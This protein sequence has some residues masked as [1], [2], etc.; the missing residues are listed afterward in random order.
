MSCKTGCFLPWHTIGT[1][2]K[3]NELMQPLESVAVAVPWSAS[4]GILQHPENGQ[5]IA[6]LCEG[7]RDFQETMK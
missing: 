2:V 7:V 6:K 3:S 5:L 4:E 1:E